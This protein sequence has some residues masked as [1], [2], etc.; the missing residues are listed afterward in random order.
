MALLRG[1]TPA[2]ILDFVR[3]VLHRAVRLLV[4]LMIPLSLSVL[5]TDFP[6]LDGEKLVKFLTL[7]SNFN[8]V[9]NPL[10]PSIFWSSSVDFQVGI[11]MVLF[12][13]LLRRLGWERRVWPQ[14]VMVVVSAVVRGSLVALD[15]SIGTMRTSN[16]RF[17]GVNFMSRQI[18]GWINDHFGFTDTL[19]IKDTDEFLNYGAQM[20]MPTYTRFGPF[21][22]GAILAINTFNAWHDNSN[23]NNNKSKQASR[24][25]LW[26]CR[27]VAIL[28]FVPL[29]SSAPDDAVPP[30]TV[31]IVFTAVFR[32]VVPCAWA[33][34]LFSTFVPTEHGWSSPST[35]Q[36]LSLGRV[37]RVLS[38]GTY[39][40]YL[41][42][43]GVTMHV[44]YGPVVRWL[45]G[46]EK[47]GGNGEVVNHWLVMKMAMVLIPVLFGLSL[48]IHEVYEKKGIGVCRRVVD[49]VLGKGEKSE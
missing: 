26:L 7:T 29:S 16:K 17:T 28:P 23:N 6:A 27:L 31:D 40:F 34:V 24:F 4:A 37:G 5:T 45:G 22:I 43:F 9:D 41:L 12:F 49:R 20:Y 1:R 38:A 3:L 15:P 39:L 36:V 25:W 10:W 18:Q 47:V 8:K 44:L 30:H 33:G 14:V 19:S 48:L 11:A 21:F 13:V 35:R 32:L 2:S 46:I 42:H